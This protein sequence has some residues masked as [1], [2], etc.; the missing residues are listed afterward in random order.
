MGKGNEG[1]REGRVR[2]GIG[3]REWEGVREGGGRE[4]EGRKGRVRKGTGNKISP[5]NTLDVPNA[6]CLTFQVTF[7][8]VED[9]AVTARPT[10]SSKTAE[11]E[12]KKE[13]IDNWRGEGEG[14]G[15]G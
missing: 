4:G 8:R 7:R 6:L 5:Y 13:K 9:K 11:R 14:E 15:G 1:G 2:K 3:M 10:G 12:G